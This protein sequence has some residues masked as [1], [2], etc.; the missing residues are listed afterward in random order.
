MTPPQAQLSIQVLST[1]GIPP[2]S[3]LGQPG[4]QGPAGTGTQGAGVKSTGGGRLVAGFATLLH[5]AKGGTFALGLKSMM[6]AA[7]A[8]AST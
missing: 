4:F 8:P 3:T 6:L 5:M 7:G 2:M 1:A